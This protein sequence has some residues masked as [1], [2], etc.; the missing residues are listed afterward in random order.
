MKFE[1]NSKLNDIQWGLINKKWE[2]TQKDWVR[3]AKKYTSRAVR[4]KEKQEMRNKND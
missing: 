3:W 1:K 4:R 2:S